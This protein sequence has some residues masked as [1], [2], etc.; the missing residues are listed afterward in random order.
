MFLKC[1]HLMS[2]PGPSEELVEIMTVSGIAEL[3]VDA[4]LVNGEML[5]IGPVVKK[6]NG[7]TLVELPREAL[8]GQTRVW[9]NST[10]LKECAR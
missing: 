5:H 6:Q 3:I 7:K 10:D 1:R 2:G 4:D 9:V 8:S